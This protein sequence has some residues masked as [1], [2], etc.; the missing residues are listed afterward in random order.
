MAKL[1]FSDWLK[2]S[3]ID[4]TKLGRDERA[5]LANFHEHYM[6]EPEP[7]LAHDSTGTPLAIGDEVV[8]EFNVVGIHPVMDPQT[9]Q[10]YA[11]GTADINLQLVGSH[12]HISFRAN[13]VRKV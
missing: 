2:K 9:G 10:P 3:G 5:K 1:L 12:H 4:E 11:D 7:P 6:A 8:M 13:L